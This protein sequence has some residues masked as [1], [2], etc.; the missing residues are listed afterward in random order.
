ML[1]RWLEYGDKFQIDE[2][3]LARLKKVYP[4]FD[5]ELVKMEMWYIANP[6]KRKKNVYRFMVN[7]LNKVL[8]QVEGKTPQVSRD[9]RRDSNEFEEKMKKAKEECAPPPDDWRQ[10]MEK[11]KRGNRVD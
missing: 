9:Y 6:A 4:F 3:T 2:T 8:G 11:L 7:W 10:M 5:K 1:V